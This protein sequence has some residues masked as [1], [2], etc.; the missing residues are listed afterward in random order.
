MRIAPFIVA[1]AALGAITACTA[2]PGQDQ[3]AD[4]T[5]ATAAG[6]GPRQCLSGLESSSSRV[7]D[8]GKIVFRG[9]GRQEWVSDIGTCPGLRPLVT[10]I[11]EKHGSQTCVNDQFRFV[12]PPLTIPGATCR[13]GP[14]TPYVEPA[15][16][17]DGD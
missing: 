9:A 14:F 3:A 2:L 1:A 4:R 15:K 17:A 12:D 13:L 16:A 11:F 8:D 7:T 10:L 5:A 6:T